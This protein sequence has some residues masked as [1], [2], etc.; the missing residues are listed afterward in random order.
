MLDAIKNFGDRA[1]GAF[2]RFNLHVEESNKRSRAIRKMVGDIPGRST[3][4]FLLGFAVVSALFGSADVGLL[5]GAALVIQNQRD[6]E[7]SRR[8]RDTSKILNDILDAIKE[9]NAP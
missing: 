5:L 6:I 4:L 3:V 7:R 2:I 8:L 9:R 1:T